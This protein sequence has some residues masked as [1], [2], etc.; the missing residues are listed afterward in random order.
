MCDFE[1]CLQPDD[2]V[3]L[4][5]GSIRRDSDEWNMAYNER[6][7]VER[8]FSPWK[9]RHAL[10][11]YSLRGLPRVRLLI[12][13]YAIAEVAAKIVKVRSIAALPMVA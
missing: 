12:Q 1:V 13:M 3:R 7:S 9:H 2:D 5:G 11:S 6:P 8:V 4:L 10:E